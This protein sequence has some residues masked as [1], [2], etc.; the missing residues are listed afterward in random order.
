MCVYVY[1][2]EC[3]SMCVYMCAWVYVY[4]GMYVC[5]YMYIYVYMIICICNK[6]ENGRYQSQLKNKN[7][8]KKHFLQTKF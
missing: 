5:M 8:C 6:L 2:C 4:V 3:I 1:I 7:Y